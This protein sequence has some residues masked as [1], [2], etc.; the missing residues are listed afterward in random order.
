MAKKIGFSART[1]GRDSGLDLFI[2]GTTAKSLG[3]EKGDLVKLEVSKMDGSSV[4]FTRKVQA[5]GEKYKI[6][7]PVGRVEDLDLT[8][9]ELV[10]VKIQKD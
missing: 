2:P 3:L 7:I 8:K 9:K 6:Y 5:S 1:V 4:Q 10:D